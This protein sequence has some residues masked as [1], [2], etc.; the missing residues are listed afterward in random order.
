MN[1]KGLS[2][3]EIYHL[4]KND[5]AVL[6]DARTRTSPKRMRNTPL[7]MKIKSALDLYNEINEVKPFSEQ[8]NYNFKALGFMELIELISSNDAA[9]ATLRTRVS[10]SKRKRLT[11][12]EFNRFNSAL[13]F[14]K[15]NKKRG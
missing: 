10:P 11:T 5:P 9:L 13:E 15:L 2:K 7:Y 4:I 6:A 8:G 14:S 3:M 1:F 12:E